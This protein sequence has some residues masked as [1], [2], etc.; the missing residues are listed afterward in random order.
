MS[1][2]VVSRAGHSA[3]IDCILAGAVDQ[4]TGDCNVCGV[5]GSRDAHGIFWRSCEHCRG[6]RFHERDCPRNESQWSISAGMLRL[7]RDPEAPRLY[8]VWDSFDDILGVG[9]TA[10]QAIAE[11]RVQ[12][13]RF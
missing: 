5:T 1:L 12:L 10:E 9:D 3:D 8:S 11:A 2:G 6:E 13:K 4:Q 7:E